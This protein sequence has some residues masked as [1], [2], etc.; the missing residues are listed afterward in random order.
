M[1]CLLYAS[2]ANKTI[3]ESLW[4][5]SLL[6]MFIVDSQDHFLRG[7]DSYLPF[8]SA[9]VPTDA[10]LCTVIYLIVS[11]PKTEEKEKSYSIILFAMIV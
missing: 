3:F 6:K 5:K 7:W 8:P 9:F 11:L 2:L 4:G 10:S 1:T